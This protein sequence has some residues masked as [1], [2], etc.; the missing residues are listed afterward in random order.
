MPWVVD[1]RGS[2]IG[3]TQPDGLLTLIV[4]TL[5]L[6]LAWRGLAFGWIVSGF[7]AILLGRDLLK[8]IDFPSARPGFGLWLGAIAFTIAVLIQFVGLVRATLH[9]RGD[10]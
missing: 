9:R 7:V 4:G 1:D 6:A 3:L 10:G 8:L 2:R 5:A